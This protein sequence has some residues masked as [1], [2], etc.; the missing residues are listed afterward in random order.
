MVARGT[1]VRGRIDALVLHHVNP[2]ARVVIFGAFAFGSI[3]L[4]E[5]QEEP[6]ESR[7][8][9]VRDRLVSLEIPLADPQR[10]SH[11]RVMRRAMGDQF[12]ANCARSMTDKQRDCI[13]A[14][15]S[16]RVAFACITDANRP[17][18]SLARRTK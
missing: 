6:V 18:T 10:E 9:R 1:N 3:A 14:A 17:R 12:I 8:T 5:G 16:S 15:S 7:C 4:G 13:F 11:A 2:L